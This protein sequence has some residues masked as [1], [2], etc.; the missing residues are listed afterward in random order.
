VVK[1]ISTA[2]EGKGERDWA[3]VSPSALALFPPPHTFFEAVAF[4]T[5]SFYVR[6]T[7]PLRC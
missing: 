2:N 4:T 1:A 5:G 3:D 7:Y 6:A